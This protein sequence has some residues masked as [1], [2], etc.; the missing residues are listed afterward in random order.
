MLRK[1]ICAIGLVV[2][3]FLLYL[4]EYFGICLGH[5]DPFNYSLGLAWFLS[6]LI[7]RGRIL[8][9]WALAG[10]LGVVY[11]V[12][13]EL[14]EGFCLYCTIIHIIALTSIVSSKRDWE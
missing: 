12:V 14:F 13:R 3:G 9:V 4:T 6:G 1:V 7:L 5:C 8:K 11:F 10:G 2:C